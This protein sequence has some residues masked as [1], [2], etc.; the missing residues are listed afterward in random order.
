MEK[1]TRNYVVH[2]FL[3]VYDGNSKVLI[4]GTFPSVKSR[5]GQF[6]Y[7]HPRNRFWAVLSQLTGEPLP[8]GIEEKKQMLLSHGIA[9]WDVVAS[10]EITGSSDSS[11]RN[12]VP[13]DIGR[14][15]RDT[16]I[17]YVF[18]NGGTAHRLYRKYCL[19]ETQTEDVCLPST[20]PANAVFSLEKLLEIWGGELRGKIF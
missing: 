19:E 12:V 20:S 17:H 9:I 6:Y 1:Q 16:E 14:I 10:C 18:T 15:L 5:E 7:H 11:I 2:E 8:V 4:L 13:A 3:P